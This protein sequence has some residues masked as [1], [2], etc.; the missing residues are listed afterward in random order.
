MFLITK[1]DNHR[2]PLFYVVSKFQEN[3]IINNFWYLILK[4]NTI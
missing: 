3:S 4:N 2:Y 1:L